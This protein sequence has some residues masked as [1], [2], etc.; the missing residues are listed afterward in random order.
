MEEDRGGLGK[1]KGSMRNITADGMAYSVMAGLGDAYLP[2]SLVLLGASDFWIGMLAALPQ[3]F[4]GV[5]QSFSLSALRLVKD[6]KIMV[7]AGAAFQA[8]TWLPIIALLLW[9]GGLSVPLI[10]FFFSLGAGA[11]LMTNPVWSSWVAD[12]VEQNERARFFANRNKLMQVMLFAVTFGGGM[13]LRELQLNYAVATSFAIVFGIAF[14]SRAVTLLFHMRTANVPYETRL[15][16]EIKTKHLFLLPSYKNELWF[17]AFVALMNFSVQFASPF[18]TPYML[19]QLGMD[20]GTLGIL[21]AISIITKVI[22]FPYW[23][24][25]IDRFSNRTVLI[26]TAFMAPLV[27]LLWLF[28]GNFWMLA[29]FQVFSGF[30]WAG[31]DLSMFNSALSLVGRELRPSF[32]SKYNAFSC[33]ANAAGALAGGL[34]LSMYPGVGF[35][36]FSGILLVFLLS[37][38]MRMVVV[39]GFAPHLATSKDIANTTADR[40]MVF[41]LVA[42]YPT[43]G[44][45]HQVMDGWDFTRKIVGRSTESSGEMLREGIEATEEIVKEGGRHLMSRLGRKGK[46]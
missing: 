35:L 37:G 41:R 10:I 27:P 22:F 6:R 4:G 25:A 44:A 23:S 21:T 12:I 42:V 18:F 36:G 40:A 46:L 13:L 20:V 34:F 14:L 24:A 30:I 43:Q 39:L 5:S 16:N 29:A 38:V 7:M 26:A 3:L 33:I 2:A 1:R 11:S 9:P 17:L 32:I 19:N 45:V 28:S 15:M 8:L 31:Y